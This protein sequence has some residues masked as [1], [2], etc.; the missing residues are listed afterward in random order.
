MAA[1]AAVAALVA[2]LEEPEGCHLSMRIN[3]VTSEC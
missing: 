1:G 2:G 3:P